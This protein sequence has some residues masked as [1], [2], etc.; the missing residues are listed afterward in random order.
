VKF[1]INITSVALKISQGKHLR[2]FSSH[3]L[4]ACRK[5]DLEITELRMCENHIVFLPVN[6]LMVWCTASWATQRTTM[7]LDVLIVSTSIL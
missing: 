6:A 3:P 2:Q 5:F 4:P 1:G 7:C